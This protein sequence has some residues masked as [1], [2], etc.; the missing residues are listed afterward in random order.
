MLGHRGKSHCVVLGIGKFD[1]IFKGSYTLVGG[2]S[3]LICIYQICIGR[4]N[5]CTT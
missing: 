2:T 5:V 3:W 4:E 1:Y